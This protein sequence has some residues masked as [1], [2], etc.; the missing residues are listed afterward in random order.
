MW[1]IDLENRLNKCFIKQTL[2]DNFSVKDC[3]HIPSLHQAINSGIG[4]TSPLASTEEQ[5]FYG[6]KTWGF[7]NVVGDCFSFRQLSHWKG[8]ES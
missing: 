3:R 8:T 6:L 1:E 4:S 5:A 7:D 2:V